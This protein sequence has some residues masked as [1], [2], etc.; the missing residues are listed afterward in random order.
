M[1]FQEWI[2]DVQFPPARRQSRLLP[3]LPPTAIA[4]FA[5]SNYGGV[6]DTTLKVFRQE[7]QNSPVLR[8]WW[9]HSPVAA[10]A[11]ESL[12]D[13]SGDLLGEVVGGA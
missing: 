11:L 10:D 2:P 12:V 7:L 9:A 8:D 5:I 6:A 3:T 1:I 13:Y 4:Y